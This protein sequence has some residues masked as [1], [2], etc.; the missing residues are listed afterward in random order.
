MQIY[1]YKSI[2]LAINGFSDLD[3]FR[4]FMIPIKRWAILIKVE[5]C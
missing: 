3:F 2:Q 1:F 5:G 4:S